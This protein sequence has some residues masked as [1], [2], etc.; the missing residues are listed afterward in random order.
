[1]GQKAMPATAKSQPPHPK[2]WQDFQCLWVPEDFRIEGCRVLTGMRS[3]CTLIENDG[4]WFE[5]TDGSHLFGAS[6]ARLG[7]AGA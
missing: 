2:D 6:G 3:S 7:Q 5:G 1:M 4:L